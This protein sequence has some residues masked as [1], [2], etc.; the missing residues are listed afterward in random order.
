[1][2]YGL[3]QIATWLFFVIAFPIF[4]VYSLLTGK[5][6]AGLRE[7]LG[8]IK[9][10]PAEGRGQGPRIWLHAASVGEVQAARALVPQLKQEFPQAVLFLSTITEPGRKLAKRELGK[11]VQCILA[12]LDLNWIVKRVIEKLRPDIYICLE[13]ELWPVLL[14]QINKAGGRLFLLNARL[15]E[16]SLSRYLKLRGFTGEILQNFKIIAAITHSD[17][18]RYM[19]L[20]A[21]PETVSAQG[22]IKYDLLDAD[23]NTKEANEKGRQ[24]LQIHAETPVLVAGSTHTDEEETILAAYEEI[25]ARHPELVLV[26]AP[27]HL[28]RLHSIEELFTERNLPWQRLS[29]LQQAK[30]SA[31][32]ILVDTMGELA[33]LYAAATVVFCGGSLVP[34]GGHNILEAAVWGKPVFFGPSMKDFADAREIIE[35]ANAG[36]VVTSYTELASA[37]LGLLDNPAQYRTTCMRARQAVLDQQG[38]ANRQVQ[39]VK[40]AL[41]D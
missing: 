8:F 18:E 3:Y 12:P 7:R 38:T 39:L 32:V 21:N 2:H 36:F 24:R 30:R 41:A 19:S 13:T 16:K 40:Q 22:N 10:S 35:A 15:S 5:H 31:Q 25:S 1:M 34:K 9:I 23:R 6:R 17:A 4:L 20:G 26:I 14:R 33:D 37:V 27:R 28:R 29:R 11:D